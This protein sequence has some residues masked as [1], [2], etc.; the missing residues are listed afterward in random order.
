MGGK[1]RGGGQSGRE[2]QYGC[3]DERAEPAHHEK[4]TFQLLKR[5]L[6]PFLVSLQFTEMLGDLRI[7]MSTFS[8]VGEAAEE[9]DREDPR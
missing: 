7:A 8:S 4:A 9:G 5:Y 2:D 6:P 1:R 3:E